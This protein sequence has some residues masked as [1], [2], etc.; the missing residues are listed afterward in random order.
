M[1]SQQNFSPN[2][3]DQQFVQIQLGA[4]ESPDKALKQKFAT[5]VYLHF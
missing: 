4:I 3:K 5:Q 2:R 1:Y